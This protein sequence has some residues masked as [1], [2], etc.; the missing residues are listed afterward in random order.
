MVRLFDFI[1]L[2]YVHFKARF[3]NKL[4]LYKNRPP[5]FVFNNR[6]YEYFSHK[7]NNTTLNERTVEV[8]IIKD[9]VEN[10]IKNTN[11]NVLEIGN[12]LSHYFPVKWDIL[13]KYETGDNV[14]NEDIASFTPV[15]KYD[16]IVSISTFEHIGFDEGRYAKN[17]V[18]QN[19]DKFIE[20]VKN[21]KS[22]CLNDNGL[23]VMTIPLNFNLNIN[24]ILFDKNNTIF[25]QIYFMKKTTISNV[26][27]QCSAEDAITK[28]YD[29]PFPWANGLAI[30]FFNNTK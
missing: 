4:G 16:L 10:Y 3:Q 20:A 12:V 17:M 14:I 18:E 13:D 1:R 5:T 25:D 24:S 9:V 11:G 8:G 6:I 26:W 19:N 27:E 22:K 28:K 30:C 7:Y 15:N 21:V 29:N 23:F 2:C